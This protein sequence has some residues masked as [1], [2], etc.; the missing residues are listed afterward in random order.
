M[1]R[2]STPRSRGRPTERN[3]EDLRQRLLDAAEER[4]AADG[5]DATP[6][7][8]VAEDAGVNPALVHYYFGSKRE[9]MLAYREKINNAVEIYKD[10]DL[11][12]PESLLVALKHLQSL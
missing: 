7:R 5:Y 6:I 12:P 9:L 2:S 4:F 3:N 8:A 11:T 1:T 10:N